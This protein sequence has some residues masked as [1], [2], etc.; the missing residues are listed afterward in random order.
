MSKI[1]LKKKDRLLVK[2]S[3]EEAKL[4]TVTSVSTKKVNI[5]FD[6]GIKL[7]LPLT[8]KKILGMGKK[9]RRKSVILIKDWS[10]YLFKTPKIE[11][12]KEDKSKVSI[13]S[14]KLKDFIIVSF[15]KSEFYIGRVLKINPKT[16]KVKLNDGEIHTLPINSNRLIGTCK[17]SS[18]KK[19]LTLEQLDGFIQNY[20]G[21]EKKKEEIN[22]N[23]LLQLPFEKK[24][25][26]IEKEDPNVLKI[27]MNDQDSEVRKQV[28]LR[29]D[30]SGLKLMMGDKNLYVRIQVAKRIDRSELKLMMG[31]KDTFVRITVA[32]RIDQSG[33]KLMMKDKHYFIRKHV[34]K[35][36]DQS[37]L[38]LMRKDKDYSVRRE[39]AKRIDAS[40][41]KDFLYDKRLQNIVLERIPFKDIPPDLQ[42]KKIAKEKYGMKEVLDKI[43]HLETET[44]LCNH[45][46]ETLKIETGTRD[47]KL[48][49]IF[50]ENVPIL[51]KYRDDWLESSNNIGSGVLK[52]LVGG[53]IYHH[54]NTTEDI[55]KEDINILSLDTIK[56]LKRG[57]IISKA[58]TRAILEKQFP[59]KKSLTLYRGTMEEEFYKVGKKFY[60]KCN[61]LSSWTSKIKVARNFAE[62]EGTA[63]LKAKVPIE[64][65]FSSNLF[66]S[67]KGKEFEHVIISKEDRLVEVVK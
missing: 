23:E 1:E 46:K 25:N 51:L 18:V 19:A 39:V 57:I 17:K 61:P 53:E 21:E 43:P 67:F 37:E 55:L 66:W 64:D 33:L 63:V 36:I 16:I 60:A 6:D 32:L 50:T 41:L 42:G 14:L 31:D 11:K 45:F 44:E 15:S 62:G 47:E 13:N 34:A 56:D 8:S 49:Y 22:K 59:G 30:Q 4:G 26:L 48:D 29:I 7:A 65:F 20:F 24:L 28:A 3:K 27:F 2:I 40:Y 12:K 52:V 9:T 54:N 35:R 38:K 5:V 10:K 58:L